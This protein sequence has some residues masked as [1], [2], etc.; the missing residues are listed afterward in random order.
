MDRT[1]E[2]RVLALG[3]LARRPLCQAELRKRLAAR[4]VDRDSVE[5]T[6]ADLVA[7]RLLDDEALALDYIVLRSGRLRLG[8]QRLVRDLERRG[9]DRD[10]ALRAYGRAIED[11]DVDPDELL[12]EAV[13]S[14]LRRERK[15][16][17][18]AQ[19]RV[20]NALLRAGFSAEGLY[21]ELK[22]QSA[23]L[24]SAEHQDDDESP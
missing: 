2:P 20:Y 14:R 11:G 10:V 9:V 7:E 1:V 21:A 6:V 23:A 4:G 5:R 15:L 22:R 8:K 3:W 13:A 18:A 19:R 16:T 24:E 12:R 17:P